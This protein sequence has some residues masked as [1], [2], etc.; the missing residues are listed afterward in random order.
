VWD[1]VF[2]AVLTAPYAVTV[3][4]VA[5][6]RNGAQMPAGAI[7]GVNATVAYS[8]NATTYNVSGLV[9]QPFDGGHPIQLAACDQLDFQV[10][11]TAP[12]FSSGWAYLGELTK[13]VPV[14]PART[15]AVNIMGTDTAGEGAG[16]AGGGAGRTPLCAAPR[17][18]PPPPRAGGPSG[19]A[20]AIMP[21]GTCA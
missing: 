10:W 16:G 4:D 1:T 11:H 2:G 15:V 13:T 7:T 19:R 21:Y 17:P 5:S 18:P 12:V 14:S 8:L 9:V 20:V 6:T 3:A